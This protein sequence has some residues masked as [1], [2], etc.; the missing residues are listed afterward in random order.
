MAVVQMAERLSATIQ[1]FYAVSVQTRLG[2]RVRQT[3]LIRRWSRSVAHT[4]AVP[5][6]PII[7]PVGKILLWLAGL[8]FVFAGVNNNDPYLIALRGTGNIVLVVACVAVVGVLMRYCS[9][10]GLAE[11]SLALLWCLPPLAMLCAHLSFE[12]R[13]RNVLQTETTQALRLGRHFVVGYS[14][15]PEVAT[16]AE[17]GLIAGIYI[18]RTM[19][20]EEP[21]RP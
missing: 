3:S 2:A 11:K 16:L 15:F 10:R 6:M 7:R 12:L 14:S 8:L 9:R 20:W 19:S 18:A 1:D 17:K 13:K 4:P 21:R 5:A